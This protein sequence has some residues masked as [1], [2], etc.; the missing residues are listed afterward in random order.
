MI[1]VQVQGTN[2]RR[3]SDYLIQRAES[4]PSTKTDYVRNGMG[5]LKRLSVDK[6]LLRE[7]ESVQKQIR[8]LIRCDVRHSDNLGTISDEVL[9][10][11]LLSNDPDN[12]ITLTAFRLLTMD[13]LQLF[14]VMN[15]GVI[16]VLGKLIFPTKGWI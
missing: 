11:Q 10:S 5:R 16:G 2:I 3:Y 7:T 6:G 15:E 12:E 4:F 1:I 9:H 8:A 14:A 13:V